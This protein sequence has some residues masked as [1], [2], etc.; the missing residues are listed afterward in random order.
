MATLLLGVVY[1]FSTPTTLRIAVGPDDREHARLMAAFA[2]KLH[3]DHAPIRLRLLRKD[4]MIDTAQTIDS[5][6]ADL[7]VRTSVSDS[8]VSDLTRLLFTLH[9]ALVAQVPTASLIEALDPDEAAA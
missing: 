5:R 8:V 1:L 9:P 7:V 3:S 2:Q 6:E 4:G